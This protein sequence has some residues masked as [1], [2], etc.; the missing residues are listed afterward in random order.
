[1]GA[2]LG[3]IFGPVI[4]RFF[5]FLPFDSTLTLLRSR[6]ARVVSQLKPTDGDGRSMSSYGSEASFSSCYSFSSPKLSKRPSSFV[7]LNVCAS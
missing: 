3:P 7:E 1:M 5:R 4:V 6:H 2:V